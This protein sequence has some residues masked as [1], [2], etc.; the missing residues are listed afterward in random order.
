MITDRWLAALFTSHNLAVIAVPAFNDLPGWLVVFRD[1]RSGN[2]VMAAAPQLDASFG[3]LIT[4][5]ADLD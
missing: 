1:A 4:P 2:A 3:L 5:E